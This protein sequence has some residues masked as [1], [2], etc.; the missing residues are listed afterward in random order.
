MRNGYLLFFSLSSTSLGSAHLRNP[1]KY[2]TSFYGII[3]LLAILPTYLALLFDTSTFLLTIRA[4][5]LLRMF[6]VFKAGQVCERSGSTCKAF[7]QSYRKIIVFFGV[8][9]YHWC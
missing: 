2:I 5:R 6:R 3:D 8:S 1:W 9:A 4:L 7:Q